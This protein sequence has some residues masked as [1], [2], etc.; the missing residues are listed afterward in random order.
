M[1]KMDLEQLQYCLNKAL[2]D[3]VFPGYAVGIDDGKKNYI[4][5]GGYTS[6][7]KNKAIQSDTLF[8]LA[9]LSKPLATTLA[10]LVLIKEGVIHL[11]MPLEKLLGCGV[12]RDKKNITLAY[13]MSHSAGV[14]AHHNFYEK[15]ALYPSSQ[16]AAKL[17]KDILAYP[18]LTRP[19]STALY[20]DVGFIILFFIIE[21]QTKMKFEKYIQTRIFDPFDIKDIIYNPSLKG[22]ENFAATE[23]CP[24]RKKEICGEVH[25]QNT[26]VLGGVCGQAGLFGTIPSVLRFVTLLRD[27]IKGRREHPYID[28]KLLQQAVTRRIHLKKN[29][30]GLGFDTPSQP[31][32]SAGRYISKESCGHLGFTGTSF[33]LD[34]NRDI[35]VVLLTNRINPSVDNLKIRAFRPLFHDLVFAT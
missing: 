15:L 32:S 5:T 6:Y 17:L 14:I 19:G 12:P 11:D 34:L 13:L 29:C 35:V 9:S 28:Q 7:L 26:S 30:W 10:C 16:R 3:D 2:D 33:W 20:S 21:Y 25:D 23:H 18:L 1:I 8:D 24:W 22:Y 4:L 27:I 31:G